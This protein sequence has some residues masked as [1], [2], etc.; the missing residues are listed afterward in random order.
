MRTFNA[1]SAMH[2]LLV[3]ATM[4]IRSFSRVPFLWYIRAFHKNEPWALAALTCGW[5]EVVQIEL[6]AACYGIK[7]P[8]EDPRSLDP[9]SILNKHQICPGSPRNHRILITGWK[10]LLYILI[11]SSKLQPNAVIQKLHAF[12]TPKPSPLDRNLPPLA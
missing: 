1:I 4:T 7:T 11:S 10:Y 2:R 5:R 3:I 12:K 6:A 9:F 8:T